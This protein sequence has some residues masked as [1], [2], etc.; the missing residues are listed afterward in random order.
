M[1]VAK[2]SEPV[3]YHQAIQDPNWCA[4]MQTEINALEANNTWVITSLPLDKKAVGCKWVYRI[5]YN[6]D[7]SIE[8]YKV[9]LVAKGFTQTHGLDYFQTFAPVAKMTSV[10]LILAL[11]AMHNWNLTQLDINN[12]FLNGELHEEVYMTISPGIPIPASFQGKN[13]VCMQTHQV[14]LWFE[15]GS[16]RV[17]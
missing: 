10:R 17:V 13:P 2:I 16:K 5:K 11:A 1:P 9:R 3:H 7:G 12:A 6:P 14:P 15:A 8:R 4:S